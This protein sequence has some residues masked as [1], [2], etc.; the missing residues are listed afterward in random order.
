VTPLSFHCTWVQDSHMQASK[1]PVTP[2]STPEAMAKAQQLAPMSRFKSLLSTLPK[3]E[4]TN[5]YSPRSFTVFP[6]LPP[7]LRLKI[8]RIAS[9]YPRIFNFDYTHSSLTIKERSRLYYD[10]MG[11]LRKVPP[12]LQV[13]RESRTEALIHYTYHWESGLLSWAIEDC[14]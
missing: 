14:L 3:L 12:V 1:C 7:E 2:R 11:R 5:C 13:N 8:W 6:K 9:F 4:L 10:F